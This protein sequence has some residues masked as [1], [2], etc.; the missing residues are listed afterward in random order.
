[1]LL[2]Q[3]GNGTHVAAMVVLHLSWYLPK[4]EKQTPLYKHANDVQG[5]EKKKG[6]DRIQGR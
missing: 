6:Q 1:M 3:I 5:E 4:E 2:C